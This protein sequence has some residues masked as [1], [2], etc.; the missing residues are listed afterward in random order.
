[1]VELLVGIA[2][3]AILA[4]L[5]LPAVQSARESARRTQCRNNLRQIAV[6]FHNHE[7]SFR[8]F[9]SGGWG[10]HWLGIAERRTGPEQPGGWAFSLLTFLEQEN[11]Q[12]SVANLDPGTS[13]AAYQRM[14]RHGLEVFNCPSRRDATAYL[15]ANTEYYRA[16]LD[17][18]MTLGMSARTDYA[19]NGGTSGGCLALDSIQRRTDPH[20]GRGGGR[21]RGR[22]GPSTGRVDLC[23]VPPGDPT[24]GQT[25]SLAAGALEAHSN[26]PYD[27]LGPCDLCLGDIDLTTDDPL[28][29]QEGDALIAGGLAARVIGR[30]DAGVPDLQDGIVFRMSRV[31]IQHITDGTSNTYLV[32]EKY[33]PADQY[34]TG[35]DP[36]DDLNLYVGFSNDTIRWANPI[37]GPPRQDKAGVDNSNG[38]GSAHPGGFNAAFAD[39]SVRTINYDVDQLVHKALAGRDDGYVVPA[40]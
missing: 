22:G 12:Q 3:I 7:S 2:V 18:S 32:A 10:P 4:A 1:M 13:E 21:G 5:I 30:T 8:H 16:A 38:F 11:L 37:F 9:P 25:M 39:G 29:L 6:A 27:Y 34:T 17:Q 40:P 31:R 20:P 35:E 28:T 24:Q 26:H 19:A 36:G 33:I 15:D 14:S 23:H